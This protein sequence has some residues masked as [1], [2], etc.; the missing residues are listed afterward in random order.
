MAACCRKEGRMRARPGAPVASCCGSLATCCCRPP[1]AAEGGGS[2]LCGRRSAPLGASGKGLRARH[3]SH[4]RPG[5]ARG[6]RARHM[7]HG[8]R[9]R[10]LLMGGRWEGV[11]HGWGAGPGW[12]WAAARVGWGGLPSVWQTQRPA[13]A[14][15]PW[16]TE[17]GHPTPWIGPPGPSGPHAAAAADI[18]QRRGNEKLNCL[19]DGNCTSRRGDLMSHRHASVGNLGWCG[20][21]FFVGVC[22]GPLACFFP[23]LS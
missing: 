11:G 19:V 4:K 18:Q 3:G 12:G 8:R 21:L 6:P 7:G 17:G 10:G 5:T 14:A 15:D 20:L 2:R 1:V 23:S 16:A 22:H 9:A 13:R